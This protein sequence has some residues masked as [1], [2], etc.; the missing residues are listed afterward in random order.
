MSRQHTLFE[1]AHA[2]GG[3]LNGVAEALQLALEHGDFE[4]V[5]GQLLERERRLVEVRRGV[6]VAE[7]ALRRVADEPVS[8]P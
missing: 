3:L 1:Y 7:P 4:H 2:A 6:G 5:L 8:T